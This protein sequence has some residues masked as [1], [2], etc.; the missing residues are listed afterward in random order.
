VERGCLQFTAAK[1]ELLLGAGESLEIPPGAPHGVLAIE[2]SV[3]VD[4]FTPRREDWIAGDDAY[5]RK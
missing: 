3:V 4:L 2:D 5:L 1:G